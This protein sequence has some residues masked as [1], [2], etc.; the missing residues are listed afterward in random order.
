VKDNP[1]PLRQDPVAHVNNDCVGCGLCGE[2]ADAAVLC[3]SFFRADIVQNPRPSD[4][5][6][7]R[8]R[9]RVIAWLQ[10]SG[11]PAVAPAE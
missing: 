4:R 3:P 9:E 10:G 1:D 8:F 11:A 7:R 5:L 6:L 2:V